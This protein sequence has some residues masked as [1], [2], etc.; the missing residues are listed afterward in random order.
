MTRLFSKVKAFVDCH[1]L[2]SK[3]EL[4]IL[5]ITLA[6]LFVVLSVVIRAIT[7]RPEFMDLP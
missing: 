5:L 7:A 3:T 1:F 6:A 2:F 4:T